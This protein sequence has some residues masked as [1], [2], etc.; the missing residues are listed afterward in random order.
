ML[1]IKNSTFFKLS[2]VERERQRCEILTRDFLSIVLAISR[3]AQVPE[4][5]RAQ[6]SRFHSI[7]RAT[8][9]VR[10]NKI[11]RVLTDRLP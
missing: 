6:T 11:K 4:C 10:A 3:I 2:T 8:H 7:K 1:Y 9:R 5:V